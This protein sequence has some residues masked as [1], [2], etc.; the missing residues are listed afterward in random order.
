MNFTLSESGLVKHGIPFLERV[1][2]TYRCG[3][4]HDE[5]KV[6]RSRTDTIIMKDKLQRDH[7]SV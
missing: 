1:R 2:V 5:C 3:G 4:K 7:S 6:W